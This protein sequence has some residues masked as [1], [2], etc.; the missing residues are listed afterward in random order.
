[1]ACGRL[2]RGRPRSSQGRHQRCW[3]PRRLLRGDR[4][5]DTRLSPPALFPFRAGATPARPPSFGSISVAKE[6]PRLTAFVGL[7]PWGASGVPLVNST[8]N[9][10]TLGIA[11]VGAVR[12][13]AATR[14]TRREN[15]GCGQKLSCGHSHLHRQP[16]RYGS[17]CRRR[18][19]ALIESWKGTCLCGSRVLHL[20][21][22]CANLHQLFFGE[23]G[24][25]CHD[26]VQLLLHE[27]QP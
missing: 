8:R 18:R 22:H 6:T 14:R 24:P 1:M 20:I 5:V 2:L 11:V 26:G 17:L 7:T 3:C 9:R 4:F 13:P 15:A 12:C 16:T 19:L 21:H 27:L 23:Y 25:N 10:V